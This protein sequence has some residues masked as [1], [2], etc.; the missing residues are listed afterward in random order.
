LMTIEQ[1]SYFVAAY[2]I[3][4]AW[5]VKGEIKKL[6]TS[7]KNVSAFIPFIIILI[8]IVWT[9]ISSSV[10]HSINPNPSQE[11]L[12][13]GNFRLLEIDNP[14]EI[15]A[16]VLTSPQLAVEALRFDLPNK[17]LYLV[18]TFAPS[19]FLAF[20]S[21]VTLLPSFLWLF[22]SLLSN[23][24]PY[25]QLGF[26]YPAFTLPFISIAT[27]EAIQ[28]LIGSFN[29][30]SI[31]KFLTRISVLLVIVGIILSMFVS[32]LSF[33]HKPGDFSYFR[34]YGTSIPSS[35]DNAVIEIL[36]EV[37]ENAKVLTTPIVFSQLATNTNAYVIPSKDS[38]SR[39]LYVG[40]VKYLQNINFDFIF[41]TYY[42]WDKNDA[43]TLYD[44]FIKGNNAYRLFIVG[45]G[46]E[47]YKRGYEGVPR[48]IGLRSSYKEINQGDSVII[49][50]ASSKSGKTLM[51]KSS[52]KA[53]RVAWYGPYIALVPGNYTVNFRIKVDSLPEGKILKLDVWSNSLGKNA[54]IAKYDVYGKDFAKPL[55]WHTFSCSFSITERTTNVEF[56]G[57]EI[58]SDVGIWLDYIDVILE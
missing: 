33:P 5:E 3:Y 22:T 41:F 38:P 19:C 23:W 4:A 25:Y 40:H 14:A 51:L 2:V 45:P 56:R 28:N 10:K 13:T 44:K 9:L 18:L 20:L 49:Y 17:M 50:D 48:K 12:A 21:P 53:D 35:L 47:L 52:P 31:K 37:P 42:F 15:P 39:R 58:A 36:K 43:N 7:K 11:L 16:K 30:R 27:I 32:P 6:F 8:I 55:T 1:A 46:L 34:D 54:Q 29:G 26:H 24:P 57:L